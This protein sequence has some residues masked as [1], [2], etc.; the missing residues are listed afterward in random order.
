M[1]HKP[2]MMQAVIKRK[3]T[4]AS[5]QT[6]ARV[7]MDV[8]VIICS[9][10]EFSPHTI[11]RLMGAFKPLRVELRNNEPW[12]HMFYGK[13]L[14]Y[15]RSL[16][17][18]N[19]KQNLVRMARVFGAR[20][21]KLLKVVFSRQCCF[22]G[23]RFQHRIV[24]ALGVRVCPEPCLRQ[25]LVSNIVLYFRYGVAFSDL[26]LAQPEAQERMIVLHS[27]QLAARNDKL[28]LARVSLDPLDHGYIK[29]PINY[30]GVVCFFLRQDLERWLPQQLTEQHEKRAAAQFLSARVARVAHAFR[31]WRMEVCTLVFAMCPS[32]RVCVSERACVRVRAKRGCVRVRAKR[33]CVRVRA[34]RGE[35]R[36][37]V[38]DRVCVCRIRFANTAT[39][40]AAARFNLH[41]HHPIGFR[42]A[43][44]WR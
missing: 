5:A 41:Y 15:Q 6:V 43:P 42:V 10:L 37:S 9:H 13:I 17:H 14:D 23:N 36:V 8:W 4:K 11:F 20:K 1:G 27:R 22:C 38:C 21:E 3:K 39:A 32:E 7:G 44:T 16:V 35:A 25:N 12:W 19:Y 24:S 2:R 33:G 29:G 18:S 34:K 31:R 30:W 28:K 40:K 26:L